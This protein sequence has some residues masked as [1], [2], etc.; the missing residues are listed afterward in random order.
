MALEERVMVRITTEVREKINAEAA[1]LSELNG[2]EVPEAAV[3]RKALG[4]WTAQL[5][6]AKARR[7]A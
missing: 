7:R 4:E 2:V 1:R 5:G 3:I 6:K